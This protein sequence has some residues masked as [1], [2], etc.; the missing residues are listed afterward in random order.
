MTTLQNVP[1]ADWDADGRLLV[2]TPEGRPL[3]AAH[4]W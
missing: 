1:W 2:A 4:A 3:A